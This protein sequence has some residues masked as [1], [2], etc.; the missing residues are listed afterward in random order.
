MKGGWPNKNKVIDAF[1]PGDKFGNNKN[2]PARPGDNN[3]NN[4]FNDQDL[5]NTNNNNWPNK[6]N[7]FR[8][9]NKNYPFRPNNNKVGN[10]NSPFNKFGNNNYPFRPNNN[11][12]NNNNNN[13]YRPGDNL[14]DNDLSHWPN[15]G[16]KLMNG[17]RPGFNYPN[18]GLNKNKFRPNSKFDNED[19][20]DNKDNEEAFNDLDS[21][22]LDGENGLIKFPLGNKFN[23]KLLYNFDDP[24]NNANLK[25]IL[26]QS[27]YLL[28]NLPFLNESTENFKNGYKNLTT[29]N[30]IVARFVANDV[31]V[32]LL[33]NY[34]IFFT[35]MKHNKM[36]NK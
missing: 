30:K 2:Y 26:T 36:K 16:N 17:L 13:P 24:K 35:K 29:K 14:E 34:K 8:P 6:G 19:N 23:N 20:E 18:K 4:E 32:T 31:L 21:D 1:R 33:I 28:I 9:G 25:K 11:L 12:N 3:L 7:G 5:D 10:K 15:K 27:P 22:N